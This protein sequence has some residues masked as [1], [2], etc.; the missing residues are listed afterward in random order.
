MFFIPQQQNETIMKRRQQNTQYQ[1]YASHIK[2]LDLSG[3]DVWF[4][5]ISPDNSTV[6]TSQ[7]GSISAWRLSNG[8]RVFSVEEQRV[9]AAPI[10]VLEKDNTVLLA[11]IIKHNVKLYNLQ[12]GHL[13]Q[14]LHDEKLQKHSAMSSPLFVCPLEDHSVLYAGRD[15]LSS[16]SPLRGW[17]RAAHLDTGEVVEKLQVN[18][19]NVV[20]FIGVTEPD[21]LLLVLSEGAPDLR[22]GSAV[23]TK[24]F[25]LELWD[26]TQKILFRKLADFPDKVRCYALSSDKCKALTL[27]NSR[28]LSNANIF[29]AEVKVFDLKSGDIIECM[30][31]YPSTIHLMEFIDSNHVITASRDKIVRLWDLERNVT[32]PSEESEEEAELEIVDLHGCHAICWEKNGI[33][34]VDLQAGR[35]IQFVNG[36]QPQMAFVNDSEVILASSGKLHLFDMNQ[37]QRIR[38][39]DGDVYQAGLTNSCFVYKQAQVIAVSC[40]QRSLCVFDISSGRRIAQLQCEHV[41]R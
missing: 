38:Q 37:R 1:V 17:I 11:T 12:T 29:R 32:L 33:R 25:K 5:V 21:M 7:T 19:N 14:E 4:V 34:L 2:F 30:L 36:L 26:I 27:G 16:A 9:T 31:T 23:Q 10:C 24:F 20:H 3:D 13:F 41:R 22:K 28:F 8:Q 18:P 15:N 35:F 39:F 40:D 6:V